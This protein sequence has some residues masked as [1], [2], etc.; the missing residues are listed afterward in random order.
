VRQVACTAGAGAADAPLS[1]L[2][3]AAAPLLAWLHAAGADT[4]GVVRKGPLPCRCWLRQRFN[5]PYLFYEQRR[6]RGRVRV[7]R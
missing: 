5:Q 6:G 4:S 7:A 3:A 2:D 1:A